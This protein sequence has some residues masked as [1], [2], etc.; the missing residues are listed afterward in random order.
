MAL[1]LV[2][3]IAKDL[4]LSLPPST[5]HTTPLLGAGE[6]PLLDLPEAVAR[7]LYET[8]GTLAVEVLALGERPLLPG[9]PYLEGEVVWAVRQELALK[10]MDVLAWRLGL[11]LLD[12]EKA[13]S[14][15]PRVVE[16]MAPFLGWDEGR[17]QAELREAL[18]GLC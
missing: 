9:L 2:E 11:A 13:L 1:D 8:Y 10:P 17:A 3:R 16:I 15:L 7:H 5:S 14:A 18:P 6:R 12:R 4:R